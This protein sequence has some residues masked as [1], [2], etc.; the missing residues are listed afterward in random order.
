MRG[1]GQAGVV[2][3]LAPAPAD[4]LLTRLVGAGFIPARTGGH[5]TRAV[6]QNRSPREPERQ[7]PGILSHGS[8]R[9]WSRPADRRGRE[10]LSQ[11]FTTGEAVGLTSPIRALLLAP[12][13]G[14]CFSEVA[15]PGVS[16][17][18]GNSCSGFAIVT[19]TRRTRYCRCAPRPFSATD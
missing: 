11:R 16:H 14:G 8:I 13:W 3:D 18:F 6:A 1:S 4:S 10:P 12:P 2:Q 9:S 5:L 15:F 17:E 19:G 7:S